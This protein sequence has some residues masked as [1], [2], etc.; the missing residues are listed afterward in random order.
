MH[1]EQV[2]PLQR[3]V[4]VEQLQ[5]AAQLVLQHVPLTQLPLVHWLLPPQA[6]PFAT[7][8]THEPL[9]HHA[10]ETQSPLTVHEVLQLLVPQT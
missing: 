9:W 7:L 5:G 6:L 1:F 3:H 4:P 8:G 10:V 2:T